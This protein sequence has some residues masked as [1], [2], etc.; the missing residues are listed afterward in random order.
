MEKGRCKDLQQKPTG[1]KIGIEVDVPFVRGLQAQT[2]HLATLSSTLATIR[3]LYNR[4][5]FNTIA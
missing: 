3:R 1:C 2:H 4:L 5:F